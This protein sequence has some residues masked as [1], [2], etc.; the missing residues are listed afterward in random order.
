MGGAH[1][2]CLGGGQTE[3]EGS[4]GEQRRNGEQSVGFRAEAEAGAEEDQTPIVLVEM[5]V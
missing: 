4:G 3:K 1:R 5:R 2:L